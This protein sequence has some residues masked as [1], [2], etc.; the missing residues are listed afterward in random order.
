[1]HV[2][3]VLYVYT[4]IKN[5][6]LDISII[7]IMLLMYTHIGANLQLGQPQSTGLQLGGQKQTITAGGGLQLGQNTS[8]L[9]GTQQGQAKLQPTSGGLQLGQQ[10]STAAQGLGLQLGNPLTSGNTGL[11]IGGASGLPA[12]NAQSTSTSK[13]GQTGLPIGNLG[14]NLG[15]QKLPSSTITS[16]PQKTTGFSLTGGTGTSA[17]GIGT[18]SL[19]ISKP[20]PAYT[21]P[22]STGPTTVIP[23]TSIASSAPT[24]GKKYTYKQL[25]KMINEVCWLDVV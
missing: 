15:Q 7:N 5:I 25:E 18:S 17:A 1:M 9:S 16:Q 4:Y 10:P 14:S 2:F 6:V 19:S 3:A 23:A 24:G 22:S 11:Q 21:A 20:P 13:T 8:L 12:Y